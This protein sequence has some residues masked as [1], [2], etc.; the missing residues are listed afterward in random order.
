MARIGHRC[1]CGHSDLNHT[2]DGTSQSLGSCTAT[3]QK[4]CGPLAAPE[5]IPTFDL[6]AK[7]VER[8]IVPGEGGGLCIRTCACDACTALYE[9]T[10]QPQAA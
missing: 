3:C 8:V 2:K 7:P 10:V 5:V 4:P 1:E 9:Q 6:K